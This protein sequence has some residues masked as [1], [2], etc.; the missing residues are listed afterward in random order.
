MQNPQQI[1]AGETVYVRQQGFCG[2][3]KEVVE[4]VGYVGD[5]MCAMFNKGWSYIRL[6]GDGIRRNLP[7]ITNDKRP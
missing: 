1:Q 7:N 4:S 6:D 3:S 2:W 5:A